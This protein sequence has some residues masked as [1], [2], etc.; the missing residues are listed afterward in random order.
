VTSS[1]T[2]HRT[3]Q[4]ITG[5]ELVDT[6]DF[7]RLLG[8]PYT[9]TRSEITRAYR[10]KMKRIHP[11]RQAPIQRAAAEERAK[12]LNRAYSTLAHTESRRTYDNSIK[13]QAVQ[14]QI[15]NQYFGGF[16]MPGSGDPTGAHLRRR[17]T[18]DERRDKQ[19]SDRQAMTS[20]FIFFAGVT[21]GVVLVLVFWA[22]VDALIRTIF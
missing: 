22:A 2:R 15:M 4:E 6:Q 14:D 17:P 3:R 20:V 21:I 10:E 13:A 19:R 9:A 12:L 18:A 7:Y 16:G 11:D 8:V 5:D 1:N